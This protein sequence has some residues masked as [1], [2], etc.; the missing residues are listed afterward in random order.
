MTLRQGAYVLSGAAVSF[1]ILNKL[2]MR[3]PALTVIL[4][5]LVLGTAC[6]LAFY[7]VPGVDLYIDSYLIRLWSYKCRTH[8]YTYSRL[9]RR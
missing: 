2:F 7:K 6:F 9:D 1:V 4:I 5:A 8:G 3:S